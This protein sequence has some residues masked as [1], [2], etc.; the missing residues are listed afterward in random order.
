M[1]IVIGDL[2]RQS[3]HKFPNKLAVVGE[4]VSVHVH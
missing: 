4:E 1:N 2:L 3:A